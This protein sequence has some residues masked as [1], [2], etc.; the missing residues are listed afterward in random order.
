MTCNST[1][2]EITITRG[3]LNSELHQPVGCFF[4]AAFVVFGQSTNYFSKKS[5]SFYYAAGAAMEIHKKWAPIRCGNAVKMEIWVLISGTGSSYFTSFVE[6]KSPDVSKLTSLYRFIK[7]IYGWWKFKIKIFKNSAKY[8]FS[9]FLI[10]E[11]HEK[12]KMPPQN[13]TS[14]KSPLKMPCLPFPQSNSIRLIAKRLYVESL[15]NKKK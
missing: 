15:R 8:A 1:P 9:I 5:V 13:A 6:Q 4:F 14:F 11:Y 2:R 10:T 7:N 12:L 3:A